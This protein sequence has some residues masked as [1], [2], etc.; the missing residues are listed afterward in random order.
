MLSPLW[1]SQ[2][3]NSHLY[4]QLTL[5]RK[6]REICSLR[7]FR[8]NTHHLSTG[9]QM[10]PVNKSHRRKHPNRS[11][12]MK[13]TRLTSFKRGYRS[14]CPMWAYGETC[15]LWYLAYTLRRESW[16]RPLIWSRWLTTYPLRTGSRSCSSASSAILIQ[17]MLLLDLYLISQH[18]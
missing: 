6:P 1:R 7:N 11:R 8:R 13:T 14:T 9:K 4:S 5:T 16:R 12:S 3:Y 2:Q 17:N 10:N 15:T 18:E